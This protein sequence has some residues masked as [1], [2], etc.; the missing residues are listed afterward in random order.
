MPDYSS[1]HRV[2]LHA[3]VG[4][5]CCPIEVGYTSHNCTAPEYCTE[6]VAALRNTGA[7]PIQLLILVLLVGLVPSK[8]GAGMGR[9]AR[10]LTRV[11]EQRPS[12]SV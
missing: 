8:G 7:H 10:Q 2:G 4:V 1:F 3:G 11:L 6:P 9:A 12:P 5:A